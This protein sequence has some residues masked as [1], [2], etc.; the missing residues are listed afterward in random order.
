[1]AE[2]YIRRGTKSKPQRAADFAQYATNQLREHADNLTPFI[3]RSAADKYIKAGELLKESGQ[4]KDARTYFE[5]ALKLNP[6]RP[7]RERAEEGLDSLYEKGNLEGRFALVL[8]IITVVSLMG[9]L[10]FISLNLTGNVVGNVSS[11]GNHWLG[12]GLFA[13][14]ILFAMLY[15]GR[16]INKQK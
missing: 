13:L 3:R 2:P 9:A 16:K 8:P 6:Q 1:M 10:F 4:L 12:L 7:Y 14:G 15:F 11:L 5:R